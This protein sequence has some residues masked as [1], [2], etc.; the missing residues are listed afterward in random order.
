MDYLND[1]YPIRKC[2]N[3]K[4]VRK[5]S[6]CLFGQLGTCLGVCTGQ[7]S[8]DE[9]QNHIEKIQAL[10]DGNDLVALPELSKRLD[11][12]IENLNFE[13]AALYREYYLGLQHVIG[14]QQLV[15]SSSKNRNILAVE[16]ID[17]VC[18][19][20]FFIK[21]N[22]LVDRKVFNIVT[23]DIPEL[24]QSLNQMIREKFGTKKSE[25]CELALHDFDETQ[26]IYSYLKK[27][28]SRIM[29]FWIP[30]TQLNKA[31]SGLDATV[32]KIISRI[33]SENSSD[34]LIVSHPRGSSSIHARYHSDSQ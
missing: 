3:Q 31:T 11:L 6:G 7:V 19:K 34:D 4:I 10:L 22:K 2:T 15:Q 20:L 26:I 24:R 27:N 13:K 9:Y 17:T 12:A 33:T 8:H 28:R 1:F 18:A 14:R 32:F 25:I 29:S 16:F 5:I 23:K 30:S 21:G